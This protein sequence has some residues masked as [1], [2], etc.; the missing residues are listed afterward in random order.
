[1][2]DS[3]GS[4][5]V[6]ALLH[7][8]RR[9]SLTLA[10]MA[11][12]GCRSREVH[13]PAAGRNTGLAGQPTSSTRAGPP[14]ALTLM[15]IRTG[16]A[17]VLQ[18]G[19]LVDSLVRLCPSASRFEGQDEEG[20]AS[21]GY[22]V[23]VAPNDTVWADVDTVEHEAVVTAITI[24]FRGPRTPEGIGVGSRFREV[25]ATGHHLTADDNEGAVY[26]WSEPYPGVSFRL[27]TTRDALAQGWRDTPSLI[28]DTTHVIGLLVIDAQH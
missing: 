1:M 23:P 24:G 22:D 28:P 21:V 14:C 8:A 4:T 16:R 10:L 13:H 15:P 12:A 7:L 9:T 2:R 20:A 17:G 11:V 6:E 27:G 19:M 25:L 26:V 3:L 5:V 18:V